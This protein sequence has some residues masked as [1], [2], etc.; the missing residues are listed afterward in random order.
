MKTVDWIVGQSKT[1]Y[2]VALPNQVSLEGYVAQH[3]SGKV[4]VNQS[5]SMIWGTFSL[6]NLAI[7]PNKKAISLRIFDRL[8]NLL[9][10]ER[11]A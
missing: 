2:Q 6:S 10:F 3:E 4:T 8:N 11:Q 5:V 1:V 7:K 9:K